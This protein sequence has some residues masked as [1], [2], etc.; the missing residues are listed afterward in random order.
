MVKG[1]FEAPLVLDKG[2]RPSAVAHPSL[3]RRHWVESML[4]PNCP[5][6]VL[7]GEAVG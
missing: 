1:N 5:S 3:H 2:A 4:S 6:V 7:S